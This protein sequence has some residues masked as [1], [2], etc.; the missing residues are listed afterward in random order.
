MGSDDQSP[1]EDVSKPKTEDEPVVISSPSKA[2]PS[3]SK[4]VFPPLPPSTKV[5]QWILTGH[6]FAPER[7]YFMRFCSGLAQRRVV[8]HLMWFRFP[9]RPLSRR[10]M[11][12]VHYSRLSWVGGPLAELLIAPTTSKKTELKDTTI[13]EA[14][15]NDSVRTNSADHLPP[16]KTKKTSTDQKQ[17][18]KD[19]INHN[20]DASKLSTDPSLPSQNIKSEKL[21]DEDEMMDDKDE[22]EED[23]QYLRKEPVDLND[24]DTPRTFAIVVKFLYCEEI[25]FNYLTFD[26]IVTLAKAAHRWGLTDLYNATFAYVM[27]QNL[28]AGGHGIRTFIPL[29]GQPETP[30]SFRRYFCIAVGHHFDVL[31][32]RLKA[33][34]ATKASLGIEKSGRPPLWDVIITQRMLSHVVHCIRLY[35]KKSYDDYLLDVILRYYEPM[36]DVEEED[37]V[38][39]LW[40]LNW[41]NIDPDIVFQGDG[42]CQRW[43]TRAIRLTALASCSP[44]TESLEVRI[45]W[46]IPLQ[47]LLKNES[48][49]FQTEHVYCGPYVCYLHVRKSNGPEVSLFVHIW[50]REGKPLGDDA[51]HERVRVTCRATESNCRCDSGKQWSDSTHGFIENLKFEGMLPRYPGLGWSQFLESSRLEEWRN[52]HGE[53]CGLAITAVLQFVNPKK[54]FEGPAKRATRPSS[55]MRLASPIQKKRAGLK[56][57]L[58]ESR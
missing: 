35:S 54:Q 56:M 34:S 13:F 36:P 23:I 20:S 8:D 43:S 45:P 58:R 48:W 41:D 49:S 17:L 51:R 30:E 16:D 18:S 39:L 29:V 32:P 12:A 2:L 53:A 11:L 33:E 14:G 21:V 47:H 26:E 31:Y 6:S 10:H 42:P 27:D 46:N 55:P 25:C 5:G 9:S 15:I 37:V 57:K 38:G 50:S 24:G 22:E 7:D 44:Q 1:T 40:Q 52:S 3:P 4:V 28:L 19:L